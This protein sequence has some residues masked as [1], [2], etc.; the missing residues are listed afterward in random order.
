[1]ELLRNAS[2]FIIGSLWG[3]FF[4]T[5]ALRYVSGKMKENPRNALFSR[6]QCPRCG[7]VINPLFLFPLAGYIILRGK[8]GKC[9]SLISPLYPAAEIIGGTLLLLMVTTSGISFMT[10]N[11]FLIMA[12]ALAITVIDI[13]TLTIPDS[14]LAVLL[15]LSVYPIVM[16]E[17]FF[18]NLKGLALMFVFFTVILLVFPGSFGGGDVKFASVIGLMMGLELS[19]VVLETALVTGAV[20]GIVY[21]VAT[22]KGFRSKMA[23]GPFL[24]LGVIVAFFFGKDI[25]LLYFRFIY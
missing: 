9:G 2:V 4:Y 7:G 14:L 5:L 6:S 22:R 13:R 19:L 17:S 23:F 15:V 24:A 16:N 1:M 25:I 3:S 18:D 8:C 12:T 20:S 21:A 11:I 10:F